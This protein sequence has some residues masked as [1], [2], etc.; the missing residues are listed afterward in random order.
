MTGNNI[1]LK[2][3]PKEDPLVEKLL[4]K[5]DE[6]K[7]LIYQVNKRLQL[8]ESS[9]IRSDDEEMIETLHQAALKT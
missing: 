9:C 8:P 4:N 2:T 1:F 6:L 7:T 5:L 3:P